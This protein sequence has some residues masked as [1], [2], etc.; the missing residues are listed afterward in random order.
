MAARED[1]DHCPFAD[2]PET[3]C[4]A[5]R[6]GDRGWC[7]RT[8]RRLAIWTPGAAEALRRATLEGLGRPVAPPDLDL[9]R[10]AIRAR[11]TKKARIPLG[12]RAP[13]PVPG[14]R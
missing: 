12:V 6:A 14:R 13:E 11:R 9:A 8:D 3:P 1:C 10:L 2:D 5:L 7:Q 4:A